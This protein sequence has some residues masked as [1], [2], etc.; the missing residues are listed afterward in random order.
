MPQWVV[1][2]RRHLFYL[3]RTRVQSPPPISKRCRSR[4]SRASRQEPPK[5]AMPASSARVTGFARPIRSGDVLSWRWSVA[6]FEERADVDGLLRRSHLHAR[7]RWAAAQA[8]LRP[9]R[10]PAVD[11]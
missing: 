9:P 7:W 6:R 3:L 5:G 4:A 11:A 1:D 10:A 2:R 8:V